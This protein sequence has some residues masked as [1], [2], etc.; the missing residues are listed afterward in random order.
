MKRNKIVPKI[1]II[2]RGNKKWIALRP[3]IRKMK[4]FL[5]NK[6]KLHLKNDSTI[7]IKVLYPDGS[8]NAGTY[9]D[10]EGLIWA[11]KTFVIEYLE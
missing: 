11:F 1:R 5:R 7:T 10:I 3:S 9:T 8:H 6:A 4:F 2:L